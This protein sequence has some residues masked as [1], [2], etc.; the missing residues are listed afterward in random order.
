MDCLLRGIF[1]IFA[2][3]LWLFFSIKQLSLQG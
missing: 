2:M 3:D 1:F